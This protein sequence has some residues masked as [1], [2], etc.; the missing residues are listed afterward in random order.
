MPRARCE[1]GSP[2]RAWGRRS[3]SE[4]APASKRFTPTCVGTTLRGAHRGAPHPVHPHV[5]GDDVA[6]YGYHRQDAG[7]PPRAW[8]RPCEGPRYALRD[9][10]T[11]TCVG[12]TH[13][14]CPSRSRP[15]VHPHVRGD[16]TMRCW[17]SD[18]SVGSPPRAWGRLEHAT[19]AVGAIAVHP[20]VRGDDIRGALE[21][22]HGGGSPPRAWGRLGWQAQQHLHVRFTPTCVGT[23][24]P[25]SR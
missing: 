10:F 5:R 12:T 17:F 2:P 20:H 23:T 8:G 15:A 3:E 7:S 13:R 18:V 16:D 4:G 24:P 19:N 11:P 6:T 14:R 22:A 25:R 21:C 9:R 1:H